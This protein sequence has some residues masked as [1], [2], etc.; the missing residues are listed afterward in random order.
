LNESETF[1]CKFS[2]PKFRH[3]RH[4]RTRHPAEWQNGESFA[5]GV[6]PKVMKASGPPFGVKI[7][8]KKKHHLSYY[9]SIKY[10]AMM[11]FK[12]YFN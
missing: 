5:I 3:R 1:I 6:I 8:E 9:L 12:P 4:L 7:D 10:D 2:L 11:L